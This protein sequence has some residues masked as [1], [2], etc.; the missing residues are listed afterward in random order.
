MQPTHRL[1]SPGSPTLGRVKRKC[2]EEEEIGE[3]V[4]PRAA[5]A[6]WSVVCGGSGSAVPGG[7]RD[8]QEQQQRLDEQCVGASRIVKLVNNQRVDERFDGHLVVRTQGGG[9]GDG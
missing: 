7:M 2:L 9:E 4:P 5:R 6:I 1:V 8:Q 3:E